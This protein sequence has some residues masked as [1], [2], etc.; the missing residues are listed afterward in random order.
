MRR[1]LAGA[2]SA[3]RK[4]TYSKPRPRIVRKPKGV[5]AKYRA[6]RARKEAPVKKSVRAEC[7]ER[8]GH[9]IALRGM[10]GDYLDDWAEPCNGPSEWCHM[11]SRRRS[12][13]RNQAPEIRH[14]T[15]H[16]FMGC[17]RHHAQYDGRQTP[18]LFVTSLTSK[19]AN[20]PLKI[21]QGR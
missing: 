7:V 15:A 1:W 3:V 13:T 20:G 17:A 10:A 11:H 2:V 4:L 16:S 14:D 6:K 12:Q 21:R 5:T 8:D 18:R 19:G 9:C